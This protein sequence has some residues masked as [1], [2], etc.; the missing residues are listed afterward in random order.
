MEEENRRCNFG[1]SALR[2]T[3]AGSLQKASSRHKKVLS[4]AWRSSACGLAQPREE[5]LEA[6]LQRS[7]TDGESK[8]STPQLNCSVCPNASRENRELRP[9]SEA[10]PNK[11]LVTSLL[12]KVHAPGDFQQQPWSAWQEK[13]PL[14]SKKELEGLSSSVKVLGEGAASPS[15]GS[16]APHHPPGGHVWAAA[17]AIIILILVTIMSSGSP[18]YCIFLLLLAFTLEDESWA[19]AR[20]PLTR[21]PKLLVPGQETFL[22][23]Q[24][25]SK[26][27]GGGPIPSL[28]GAPH[29][30]KGTRVPKGSRKGQ[31]MVQH[32]Q[33]K[34]EQPRLP[35]LCPPDNNG[36]R[37]HYQSWRVK[38]GLLGVLGLL[39]MG[40]NGLAIAV[41]ASSVS[42]WSRSSRLALLSL[43]A[44]D[45]ALALLVVPLNLYR[46]LELGPAAPE[47]EEEAAAAGEEGPYAY[48]RAVAFINCSLFGASLYSLAGVSLERYVA[49]FCPLRYGRLLSRRRVALLIAVAWLL[50][51]VLLA[52]LAIPAPAAVLRV[53][54]SAAALLCEPDYGSNAL[55]SLWIAGTIFCPAAGTVAFTNVRLWRAARSQRRRGRGQAGA[56]R[57]L[58]LPQLDAAARVLLP[59]VVAFFA[60]W[61]P[62]IGTVVYNSITQERVHEWV[63]FIALWLPIGSGFLNCFVYFWVNRNFRHKFQK[64]G[65]KVCLPCCPT[66][67]ELWP[68]HLH[69]I[70]ANVKQ[71]REQPG[72][73]PRCSFSV[74]LSSNGLPLLQD[75]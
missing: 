21:G 15:Q 69:T 2:Q 9:K 46:G 5:A 26:G 33:G 44:S 12:C 35:S 28:E 59:V 4:V 27:R 43:A 58:R 63:E 31:V 68:Q 74:S 73:S 60:C 53:R 55:Y 30:S 41:L 32:P 20:I 13:V 65:Q 24:G 3:E 10:L 25:R 17:A 6:A 16:P 61:A 57:R 51:A 1:K 22:G 23:E 49:V 14:K 67:Q 72:L 71:D 66:E 48:C 62:C 56:A 45:A 38:V 50:P 52:P 11:Q 47:E 37:R 54:F 7:E 40:G 36:L 64:I 42:G 19:E 29:T 70:S 75:G 18:C 34:T 8:S 39:V